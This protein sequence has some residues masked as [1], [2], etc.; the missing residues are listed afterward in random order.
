[1]TSILSLSSVNPNLSFD[2]GGHFEQVL[3]VAYCDKM[4][5]L[6]SVGIDSLVRLWDPRSPKACVDTL[7]GHNKAITK[8]VCE[9]DSTTVFVNFRFVFGFGCHALDSGYAIQNSQYFLMWYDW[10]L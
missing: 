5:I 6:I 9:P 4:D 10:F 8:V 1:M 3:S 2:C 7:R